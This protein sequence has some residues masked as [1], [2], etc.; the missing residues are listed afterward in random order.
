[1]CLHC[2]RAV[3]DMSKY[4]LYEATLEGQVQL[5]RWDARTKGPPL[6]GSRADR[7]L[8]PLADLLRVKCGCEFSCAKLIAPETFALYW[9]KFENAHSRNDQ[10]AV[11]GILLFDPR[12]QLNLCYEVIEAW[13]GVGAARVR[14]VHKALR[15]AACHELRP[16]SHGGCGR[17]PWN[18]TESSILAEFKKHFFMSVKTNPEANVVMCTRQANGPAEIIKQFFEKNP[19]AL[20]KVGARAL[21]SEMERLLKGG[22]FDGLVKFIKDHNV[23]PKCEANIV[24][25]ADVEMRLT[26]ALTTRPRRRTGSRSSGT[27]TSTRSI[28]SRGTSTSATS[29]LTSPIL[30]APA[31]STCINI[32]A[33]STSMEKEG[34]STLKRATRPARS[35][36]HF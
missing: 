15:E 19:S 9:G 14:L 30:V 7:G 28:I 34:S 20:G 13:F 23:C 21:S 24:G 12:G 33:A 35:T 17:E 29:S 1:M 11:L 6:H 31:S 36:H 32:A 26:A 10:D 2:V 4:D 22:G 27:S 18:R 5:D 25:A 8:V 16:R 3:L